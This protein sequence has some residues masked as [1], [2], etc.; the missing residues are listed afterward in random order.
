MSLAVL[1]PTRNSAPLLKEHLASMEPWIDVAGEIIVV[2]SDSRD[3]TVDLLKAF[4]PPSRTTWLSHPPGLYQSWN[5]GIQNVRAEYVYITTVGDS[6]TRP[7]LE[8]LL[9]VAEQFQCD[10]VL[11]KPRP[12]N[13]DG[14]SHLDSPWLIDDILRLR[15]IVRPQL[16]SIPDQFLFAV[17]RLQF[18]LLGSSASNLYSAGCLKQRPFPLDFGTAGDG[19]WGVQNIFDVKIAVT[20]ECF[21]TFR[22]HPKTYSTAAYRVDSLGLKLFRLAQDV[23]ARQRSSNPA[24]PSI[25]EAVDWAAL[26]PA[27]D[28]YALAQD[29]LEKLRDR[30]IPWILQP[31]AWRARRD[32][33]QARRDISQITRRVLDRRPAGDQG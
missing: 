3:G 11:S 15:K 25:L 20:P 31:A 18:A 8:H 22:H 7:G 24:L 6:I 33:G 16:L 17:T 9:Q 26:E 28:R 12:I 14:Q 27:L 23:I 4:L 13:A 30:K 21:S 19:A 2:D 1:I 29:N 10:L 5:F 32:R